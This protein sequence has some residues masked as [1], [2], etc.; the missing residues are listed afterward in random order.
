MNWIFIYVPVLLAKPFINVVS[1]IFHG[2][3]KVYVYTMSIDIS[4]CRGVGS[5]CFSVG[6]F[7][8]EYVGRGLG[9]SGVCLSQRGF[10]LGMSVAGWVCLEFVCR[11]VVLSGVCLSRY[12]FVWGMSV[13]G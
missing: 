10:V 11:G 12:G 2:K 4:L 8:L 3:V 6:G 1:I 7:V 9:L 5:M 13:A